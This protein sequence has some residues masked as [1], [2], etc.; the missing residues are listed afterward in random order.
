[1]SWG[2]GSGAPTSGNNLVIVGTDNSGLLH[3]RIFDPGGTRVTDK[4]ET[5]LPGTQAAAILALKQ[6][7]PALLAKQVLSDAEKS[8]VIT[9]AT[10]I[11]G[12]TRAKAGDAKDVV[13]L[14]ECVSL[15]ATKTTRVAMT[16]SQGILALHEVH[17]G[18][19]LLAL[20][21]PVAEDKSHSWVWQDDDPVP[22]DVFERPVERP[23]D[24]LFLPGGRHVV[25]ARP[26][27]VLVLDLWGCQ[28][29]SAFKESQPWE[30]VLA[31]RQLVAPPVALNGSTLGLLCR[32]AS[33]DY[34]WEVWN[35]K[36]DANGGTIATKDASVALSSAKPQDHH[37]QGDVCQLALVDGRVLAF[38]TRKGHWVWSKENAM[39]GS[40]DPS[41]FIRTWPKDNTPKNVEIQLDTQ[42]VNRVAF[43]SPQQGFL[44]DEPGKSMRFEWHYRV[45]RDSPGTHTTHSSGVEQYFV[46]FSPL[47]ASGASSLDDALDSDRDATPLGATSNTG[48]LVKML[49]KHGDKLRLGNN[50]GA[51]GKSEI[52]LPNLISGLRLLDPFI[53]AIAP[54]ERTKDR[55]LEIHSLLH[56]HDP[57]LVIQAKGI[58]SDPLIWGRWLFTAEIEDDLGLVVKRRALVP[59]Q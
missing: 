52:H 43:H 23:F 4:D 29:L 40:A 26:G 30:L 16:I 39:A 59:E 48:T 13:D 47:L 9:K 10:S 44:V 56:E 27:R 2:D 33:T 21:R 14:R 38:A 19:G 17:S 8:Q 3:V 35:L 49:Y 25:F 34:H 18:G 53:V 55:Q 11:A 51:I 58:V 46:E 15:T 28:G 57:K 36:H 31:D 37:L 32:A 22:K 41:T 1:M 42:I 24:P 54:D 50:N 7:I 20:L 5:K 45:K 6:Q 12:H